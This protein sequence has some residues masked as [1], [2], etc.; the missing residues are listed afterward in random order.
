IEH[1]VSGYLA[2]VGD[3]DTMARYAIELLSD[4][5]R[6]R[7]MGKAARAVA[8]ARFCSSRIVPQYEEFYRRV[9]ER[10]S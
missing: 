10:T 1:G 7:A 4:E 9:V 2:D 6:L 3:V 5:S 8:Q